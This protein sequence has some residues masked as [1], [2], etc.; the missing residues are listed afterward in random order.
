MNHG[1]SGAPI[2]SGLPYADIIQ[3]ACEQRNFWPCVAY[4]IACNETIIGQLNGKWDAATVVSEDGGHGLFQLTSSWPD[5]W[6]DPAANTAY[7]LD[8]FL[9]NARDEWLTWSKGIEG[10][11]LVR[12]IAATF[13]AGFGGAWKGHENGD[14]DLYTTDDYGARAAAIY[15][16][17]ITGTFKEPQ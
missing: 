2:P 12:A 7:A 8:H 10:T 9:L 14:V 1:I 15:E 5:N 13:N 4:A 6:E 3:A 16:R 11:D 17:L